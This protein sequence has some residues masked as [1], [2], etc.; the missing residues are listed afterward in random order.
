MAAEAAR[1][2]PYHLAPL[3]LK[4]LATLLRQLHGSCFPLPHILAEAAA[5]AVSSVGEDHTL[6]E[7]TLQRLGAVHRSSE[8]GV[9]PI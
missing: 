7:E 6:W 8:A 5:G 4:P 3:L 1:P 2:L 9:L